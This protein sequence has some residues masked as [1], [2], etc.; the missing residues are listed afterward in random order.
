M[1]KPVVN[2]TDDKQLNRDRS[3][4]LLFICSVAICFQGS[5]GVQ[6]AVAACWLLR[7]LVQWVINWRNKQEDERLGDCIFAAGIFLLPQ[8]LIHNYTLLLVLFDQTSAQV[9]T[10][11]AA[12]YAAI[13][14]A[15]TSVYLFGKDTV[16]YVFGALALS[17]FLCLE[18]S[19]S[20]YGATVVTDAIAQ[21]W[22]GI[23]LGHE[24]YLELDEVVL[25]IGYV[26][27]LF[28]FSDKQTN[29]K[30]KPLYILLAIAFFLGFKRISVAAIA[31]VVVCYLIIRRMKETAAYWF[32]IIAGCV[33]AVGCV[34][35]VYVMSQGDA[36]FQL[37]EKLGIDAMARDHFY[38]YVMERAEFSPSFLG[39]GRGGVKYVMMQFYSGYTY[40][41]SDIIKM[42]F[43]LGL[44]PFLG[45]LCL[46]LI[47]IPHCFKKRY[48]RSAAIFYLL[49]TAYTF[50]LYLTDNT[51]SYFTCIVIR[52]VM[53]MV[54]AMFSKETEKDHV[55]KL[56]P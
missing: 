46:N 22:F 6:I 42:F 34:A 47:G 25:S 44:I 31:L 24:N 13:A 55:K 29:K 15:I 28:L 4:K 56:C 21:G 16:W 39:Y 32:G 33:A 40:V 2:H 30:A 37:L 23:S 54:F 38:Q 35:F 51:E 43:E 19:V 17:W 48:G 1:K 8:L 12:T 18:R 50:V 5:L 53:P 11:N 52:T 20:A 26:V 9:L 45:W 36:V 10:T 14:L 49:V 3:E 27:L 7:M 41:H